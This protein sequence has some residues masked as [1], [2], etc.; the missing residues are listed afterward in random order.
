[1]MEEIVFISALH[2]VLFLIYF[3]KIAS[4]CDLGFTNIEH[5][6]YCS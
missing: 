2:A 1:M 5:D 6:F 4:A 3:E